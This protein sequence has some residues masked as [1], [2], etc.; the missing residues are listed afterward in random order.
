Q[1]ALLDL[2]WPEGLQSELS[3]PIA[4]LLDESAELISLASTA[5]FRCFTDVEAARS[6]ARRLGAADQELV[7]AAE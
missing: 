4:V 1:R 3:E 5:G 7:P 2:A 6:Y